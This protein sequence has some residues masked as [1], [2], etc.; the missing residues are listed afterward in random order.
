MIKC[1]ESSYLGSDRIL[2]SNNTYCGQL[3]QDVVFVIPVGLRV[4]G[5]V[6]VGHTD[7]S[8]SAAG[9]GF[10]HFLHHLVPVPRPENARFAH[11]V[12]NVRTPEP[13]TPKSDIHTKQSRITAAICTFL[14]LQLFLRTCPHYVI[15]QRAY[16]NDSRHMKL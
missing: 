15:L 7:G 16:L 10:D 1:E 13:N 5:K 8:E 12:Q 2:N 9:H 11:L 4:S 3:G 14:S 6:P